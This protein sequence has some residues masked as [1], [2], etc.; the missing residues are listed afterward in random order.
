MKNQIILLIHGAGS[1]GNEWENFEKAF[2][3]MGNKVIKPTLRFHNRDC[4]SNPKLGNISI[5]DYVSDMEKLIKNLNKKPIIIG[6]S[7]G[8]LIALILCSRGHGKLG[9]FL[10]PAAPSGINAIS[11]SVIRIFI[12]NI[13]RWKFW[14]KPVPP[15]FA[16]AYFG[17]LH[18]LE[19]DYALKVFK[20]NFSAESGRALCEIGFPFFFSNSPTKVDVS[21]I[22]CPTLIIGAGRDRIT[23]VAISKKLKSKLK[24]KAELIIFPL[25]SHYIMEGLEFNLVFKSILKW[26]NKKIGQDI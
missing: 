11:L 17:V 23:P 1:V 10:T 13:F 3:K 25:F 9:I 18:D 26:V 4:K 20:K 8:G 22:K 6:H 19:R 24:D 7:M 14:C 21:S 16:S 15:N 5:L 12:M 2:S